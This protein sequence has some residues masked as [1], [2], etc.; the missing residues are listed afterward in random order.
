MPGKSGSKTHGRNK[1]KCERYRQEHRR[2]KNKATR[3]KAMIKDLSPGNNMRKLTQKRIK[4]LE[5]TI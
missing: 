2:E 3:L 4:E 5:R 1:V